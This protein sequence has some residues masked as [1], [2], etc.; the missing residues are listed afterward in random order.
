MVDE[1]RVELVAR[2]VARRHVQRLEVVPVGLDLRPLGDREAE[3]DEHVLEPLPRLGDDV[4]VAAP[5]RGGELGEVEPLGRDRR[6]PGR[7]AQL[8]PAGVDRLGHRR[9]ER[10]SAPGRRP[11]CRRATRASRASSSVGRA[12]P[13]CRARR[14]RRGRCRRASSLP[15]SV[16][17]PR[18]ERPRCHR[19]QVPPGTANG[20]GHSPGHHPGAPKSP[21]WQL[22]HVRKAISRSRRRPGPD[23]PARRPGS[24]TT[25][26]SRARASVRTRRVPSPGS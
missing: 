2:R 10:S 6:G 18:H 7:R 20:S 26:A 3:P 13:S 21:T 22:T 1:Q 8:G 23:S 12:C 14:G 15:R 4:R 24:P 11:A 5:R 16:S 19:A 25:S 17:A 9:A